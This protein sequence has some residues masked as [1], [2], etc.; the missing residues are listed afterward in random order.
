MRVSF[1][2]P[3]Y[4]CLP[5][6][7]AMLASLRETLPPGLAHEF[8]FVDDGSTD[9]TPA[10][11]N[12]LPAPCRAILN[13]KNLGFAATCNRGAGAATGELLLFLNNDLVLQPRWLEPM[14][15]AFDRIPHAGIVGNV[16]LLFTDR[17]LDHAGIVIGPDGKPVHLKTLPAGDPATPGYA[18]MPA[19]TGACFAIPRELFASLG[20]FDEDFKNG[21]EDVDL[22]FRA[23]AV[24][25]PT[26]TALESTVLHHV[27]ASPGRK[28]RNEENSYRLFRKW[29]EVLEGE[30]RVAWCE[31]Y[32]A[33]ARAGTV[34]RHPPAEKAAQAFLRRRQSRP[35]RWAETNVR[36]NL[37]LEEARWERLFPEVT[38]PLATPAGIPLS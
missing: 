1:I 28:T 32:L 21:C 38:N 37:M 7:Q 4:N 2:I 6:T 31:A 12:S 20:G 5:L 23:R 10:W 9:G 33:D 26:W 14:L 29:R 34:P 30:A 24:G 27:S 8:I 11:L 25:R 3:L 18:A 15:A 19:V 16:Q 17:T 22:C 36:Q 13:D 35:G